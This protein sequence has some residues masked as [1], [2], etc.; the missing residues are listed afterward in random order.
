MLNNILKK[1]QTGE[2]QNLLKFLH[3]TWM[4]A[5]LHDRFNMMQLDNREM[6]LEMISPYLV[7]S[8]DFRNKFKVF[9][10]LNQNGCGKILEDK[11]LEFIHRNRAELFMYALPNRDFD[12]EFL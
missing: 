9:R 1:Y 2:L 4:S 11:L 5:V 10:L 3:S 8:E 7:G 12:G 6:M